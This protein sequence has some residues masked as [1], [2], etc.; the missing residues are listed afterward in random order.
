MIIPIKIGNVDFPAV[1]DTAA[2]VTVVSREVAKNLDLK[3][4]SK[5]VKLTGAEQG[6]YFPVKI[7]R[8]V[9]LKIGFKKIQWD[10]YVAVLENL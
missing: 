10:L 7:D 2:Q 8:N 9:H 6:S 4:S 3:L 1:V 5:V